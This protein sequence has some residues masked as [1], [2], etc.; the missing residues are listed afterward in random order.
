VF[1]E[2]TFLQVRTSTCCLP[3]TGDDAY[4]R[5]VIVFSA[6]NLPPREDLDHQKLLRFHI[7]T[8][9]WF[10]VELFPA[11]LSLLVSMNAFHFASVWYGCTN[12]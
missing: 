4:G 9:P 12:Y 11:F 10:F 5:K 8:L 2:Q 3:V 7:L 6:C 1:I